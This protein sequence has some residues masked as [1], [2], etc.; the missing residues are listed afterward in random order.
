MSFEKLAFLISGG[1][2]ISIVLAIFAMP[3]WSPLAAKNWYGPSFESTAKSALSDLPDPISICIFDDSIG[4]FVRSVDELNKNRILE[5]AA[6]DST[7][8]WRTPI[9]R[10]HFRVY[11]QSQTYY[12]SFG[13]ERFLKF[14]GDRMSLRKEGLRMC[15]SFLESPSILR[16]FYWTRYA[17]DVSRE[18][19]CCSVFPDMHE[20]PLGRLVRPHNFGPVD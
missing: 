10:P 16:D 6:R 20:S 11:S 9:R 4:L 3:F 15:T 18:N 2:I 14:A 7:M 1:A 17:V 13:E 5:R 8:L 19:F 12:W